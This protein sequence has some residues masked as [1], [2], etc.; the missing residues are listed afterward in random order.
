MRWLKGCEDANWGPGLEPRNSDSKF[1]EVSDCRPWGHF[2][3]GHTEFVITRNRT[4]PEQGW[5][6]EHCNA[7]FYTTVLL[8]SNPFSWLFFYG[9][10]HYGNPI[11]ARYSHFF[12]RFFPAGLHLNLHID[13]VLTELAASGIKTGLRNHSN[14]LNPPEA[15]PFNHPPVFP[16]LTVHSSPIWFLF[17]PGLPQCLLFLNLLPFRLFLRPEWLSPLKR[18]L[19]C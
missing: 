11:W 1:A 10:F 16:P 9:G 7:L 5:S 17:S 12:F 15:S 3:G 13:N 19:L 14:W 4:S 6:P 18:R 8:P 2:A